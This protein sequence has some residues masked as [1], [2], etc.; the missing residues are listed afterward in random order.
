MSTLDLVAAII[1][2]DATSI[3][4]A[5]NAAMA[6]KISSRLEDK[7]QEMTQNMFNQEVETE[8]TDD[9]TA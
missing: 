5:F 6:E 4:T 8:Y 3:D 9:E 7:R 1:N 2:K